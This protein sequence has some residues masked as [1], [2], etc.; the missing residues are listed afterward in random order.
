MLKLQPQAM[1]EEEDLAFLVIDNGEDYFMSGKCEDVKNLEWALDQSLKVHES[2]KLRIEL[3]TAKET[4]DSFTI[5]GEELGKYEGEE[6][7]VEVTKKGNDFE[8]LVSI[9]RNDSKVK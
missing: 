8:L 9:E 3:K 1:V 5:S 4:F 2:G 7:L 6:R